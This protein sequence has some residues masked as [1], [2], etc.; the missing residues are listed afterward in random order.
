MGTKIRTYPSATSTWPTGTALA[1][2]TSDEQK[3]S[4][5]MFMPAG[6]DYLN[7]GL[8]IAAIV[9]L[10]L[11]VSPV[12]S[13]V[14]NDDW[15]YAQSVD[16][17]LKGAYRPHEYSMA[18]GIGHIAWGAL[19]QL[20]LGTGF[21]TLT[22]ANMIMAG[23]C[24]ISF[25][26][27]LRHLA[28][29]TSWAILGVMI[30]GSSPMFI[31]LSYSFMT[32]VTFLT[33]ALIA[34]IFYIRAVQYARLNQGALNSANSKRIALR[35]DLLL[36]A[37]SIL[38]TFAY[39]TRQ[40]GLFLPAILFAYIWW[41]K[42]GFS[43]R[44]VFALGALPAISAGLFTLWQNSYPS[45]IAAYL[46]STVRADNFA[47]LGQ[48]LM[49]RT[50]IIIVSLFIVGLMLLPLVRINRQAKWFPLILV[51][52]LVLLRP[53]Y[54]GY[55]TFLPESS[56]NILN[57]LGLFIP[58]YD[59]TQILP[60]WLWTVADLV[61]LAV[62][63]LFAYSGIFHLARFLRTA[64]ASLVDTE[65]ETEP[66]HQTSENTTAEL[67]IPNTATIGTPQNHSFLARIQRLL[68]RRPDIDPAWIVY[69][70]G[71]AIMLPTSILSYALFDRYW[72]PVLPAVLLLALRYNTHFSSK[73]PGIGRWLITL[74][75][76]IFAILFQQD[77]MA[78]SQARWNAG[79]SLVQSGV[80]INKILVGPEW[81][82]WFLADEG[83]AQFHN[84]VQS[85][86]ATYP[87]FGVIDP[88]YMVNGLPYK[89][90]KEIGSIH[91]QSWLR[92]QSIALVLKRESR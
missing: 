63:S 39:L 24:L 36:F 80:S 61:S 65:T 74:T 66:L 68:G 50:T 46:E 51:A 76:L 72:L 14:I 42:I 10:L 12:R 19:V 11:I 58:D 60:E 87:P 41:S 37:G 33:Y 6:R 31:F 2:T 34:S 62:I 18:T 5:A 13:F 55:G 45:S 25:Y 75:L 57:R 92:G 9:G 16:A 22:L 77:Y 40:L 38:A 89:G 91:Y 1:L 49:E 15:C 8:I 70:F 17:L 3:G 52:L 64:K 26:L 48:F 83:A 7:I 79:E 85:G 30:L 78:T 47:H 28:I 59:Q 35:V 43:W 73:A 54:V 32:D 29:P 88:E 82:G 90:Y 81:A 4:I 44:R 71:I 56:G 20:A 69:G 21:T 84:T 53:I 27:L 67:S 86:T 23:A